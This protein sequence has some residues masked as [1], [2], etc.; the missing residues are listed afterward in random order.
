VSTFAEATVVWQGADDPTRPLVI[1]LLG[2]GADEA[3]IIGLADHLPP[4]P[5]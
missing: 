1:L 5:G 2:R 4:G 3:R